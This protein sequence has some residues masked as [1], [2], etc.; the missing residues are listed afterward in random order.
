M[1]MVRLKK[2]LKIG[3]TCRQ[4]IGAVMLRKALK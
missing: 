4:H 2:Q 1:V 3:T